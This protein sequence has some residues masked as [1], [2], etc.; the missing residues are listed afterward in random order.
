MWLYKLSASF[1][2][3]GVMQGTNIADI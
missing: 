3:E 1:L 2:Y